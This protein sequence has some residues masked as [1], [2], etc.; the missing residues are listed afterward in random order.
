MKQV[1]LERITDD[2]KQTLGGIQIGD[3]FIAKTLELG[4][5]N[6][7]SNIS[8]IPIGIYV[9]KYTRSNRMSLKANKDVYTY[10]LMDVPN[11]SGI[12]IHSA[13]YF[14]QLLGCIALGDST[15]DIDIDGELDVLHSGATVAKFVDLMNKVDFALTIRGI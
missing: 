6:N 8:C 9:C 1:I 10:E 14:H 4:W 5:K 7:A 11:R 12:R 2:G 3:V 15:K 13:N